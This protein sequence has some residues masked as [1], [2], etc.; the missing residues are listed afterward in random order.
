[1]RLGTSVAACGFAASCS[2]ASAEQPSPNKRRPPSRPLPS[3]RT[4]SPSVRAATKTGTRPSRSTAHGAKNDASGSMCQA[5]HGDATEHL[6]DPT[7]AKP[8]NL[9]EHGHGRPSRRRSA[10]PATRAI[11]NLAFWE[12]GKHAL[13]DVDV[14]NCHS[15]HGKA[16]SNP[17]DRTV[18]DDVPPEQGGHLRHVPPAHPRGDLE[19]VAS[20]DHRRQD[21]VLRLPQSARRDHAGDA[22]AAD[23]QRPVHSCHADKRGPYVFNHPPVEENCATCH[24]PHGSVA[25]QAAERARAEP[26]P[27]LPRRGRGIPGR[28]TAA[29][30]PGN[31]PGRNTELRA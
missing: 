9:F 30:R 27:G 7:K 5:C 16:S 21:Q 8:A 31:A 11:G 17:T 15:I 10:S 18:H 4:S 6:K 14:R 12:S 20:P 29:A 26:V 23:D 1:M 24:N 19:A 2:R 28:S 3:G 25:L 13:N 22:E